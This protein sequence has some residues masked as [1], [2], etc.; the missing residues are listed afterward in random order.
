MN[1]QSAKIIEENNPHPQ[2]EKLKQRGNKAIQSNNYSGAIKLY[3]EAINILPQAAYYSNRAFCKMKL[4]NYEGAL[5]DCLEAIKIDKS[6]F[7]GYTRA[8]QCYLYFGKI[9]EALEVLRTGIP[10]VANGE[11]LRKE[12]DEV[13]LLQMQIDKLKSDVNYKKYKEAITR[14]EMIQEKCF[15]DDDLM[16]RKLEYLCLN[17]EMPKARQYISQHEKRFRNMGP[18]QYNLH[19]ACVCR[20]ENKLDEANKLITEK[21]NQNPDNIELQKNKK[22][23]MKMIKSKKDATNLFKQKKYEEAS[24]KYSQILSI[25]PTNKQ[26]NAIIMSNKATCLKM[27]GKKEEALKSFKE[28]IGINPSYG[29]AYLKMADLEEENEDFE[30]SRQSLIKAKELD[31]K[32]DLQMRLKRVTDKVNKK[33]KKDYYKV[34]GVDKK[35][36]PKEIKKAYRKLAQKWHPDKNAENEETKKLASRKFKEIVEANGILSDPE[37]RRRYDIGGFDMAGGGGAN[38]FH[39]FNMSGGFPSDIF[40]M[41]AGRNS[42]FQMHFGG[43]RS[44]RSRG[45]PFDDMFFG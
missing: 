4:D 22:F 31:D 8:S 6:F 18:N 39:S 42:G 9:Y 26:F 23:I 32:L 29:K 37:K 38:R 45:S 27:M 12:M 5:Q 3:T 13:N 16:K 36:S 21:L 14:V 43:G 24:L 35:A 15:G 17:N 25:D 28:A 7:R 1:E 20:Y 11:K 44:R 10:F 41:F 34:L 19:M 40:S 33:V 30:A 2:A